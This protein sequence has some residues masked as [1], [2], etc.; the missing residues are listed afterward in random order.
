MQ[1]VQKHN[2]VDVAVGAK[3]RQLRE[4]QNLTVGDLARHLGA[5][6][7]TAAGWE[8]GSHRVSAAQLFEISKMLKVQIGT[9]FE[10]VASL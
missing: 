2:S 8:N 4:S 10:G 3:L 7:N 6:E 9:F 1:D 5:D